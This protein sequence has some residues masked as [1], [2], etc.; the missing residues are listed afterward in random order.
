MGEKNSQVTP[1]QELKELLAKYANIFAGDMFR[2]GWRSDQRH[3]E[4]RKPDRRVKIR[5][6][7]R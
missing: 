7:R 2:P 1:N 6:E 4:I 3:G 5:P